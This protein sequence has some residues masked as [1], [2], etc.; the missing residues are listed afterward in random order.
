M[1]GSIAH[2]ALFKFFS[3]LPKRLGAEQ[4]PAERLDEALEFL[5]ECL[6]DAIAGGAESRLELTDLQRNELQPGS[7]ARPRGARPGRGRVGAPARPAPVRGLVRLGALGARAPAR[8]RP[9][10][11]PPLRED[12]PASTSTRSRRAG[13]SGTTSRARP[14]TRRLQIEKRAEAP[15]PAVHARAARP[16]RRRAAR[17]AVSA[18]RR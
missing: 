1:R 13:S 9:R 17:W 14:R 12:R 15:D 11:V 10:D 8:P 3:G 16:R 7:L 6:D 18:A 5:R 2:Q 4:V